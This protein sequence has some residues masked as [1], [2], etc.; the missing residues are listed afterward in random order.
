MEYQVNILDRKEKSDKETIYLP[1][2]LLFVQNIYE[3]TKITWLP[4]LRR[5][6]E[7]KLPKMAPQFVIPC[8]LMSV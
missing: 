6:L 4:F 7:L 2:Y 1:T 5:E 8:L 3:D